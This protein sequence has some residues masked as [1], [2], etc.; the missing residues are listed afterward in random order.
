[1]SEIRITANIVLSKEQIES[2]DPI[3]IELIVE[4][5]EGDGVTY[6]IRYP[7]KAK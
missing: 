1:M 7:K 6:E 3:L 4:N 5:E 2:S